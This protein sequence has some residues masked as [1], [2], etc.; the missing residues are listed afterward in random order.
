M[1]KQIV[2]FAL[3][4]ALIGSIAAGCGSVN[5]TAGS[6]TTV[7]DTTSTTTPRDTVVKTDT[8]KRDT[9]KP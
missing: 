6:D 4:T 8:V 7:V 9:V 3:V 1:K 5:E 2:S